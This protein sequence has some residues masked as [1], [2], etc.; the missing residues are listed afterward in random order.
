M[1]DEKDEEAILGRSIA[2]F[3]R[4]LPEEKRGLAKLH[5]EMLKEGDQASLCM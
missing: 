4:S 2:S 5:F 3:L 1:A